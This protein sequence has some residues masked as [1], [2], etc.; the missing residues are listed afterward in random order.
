[1]Y[2]CNPSYLEAKTTRKQRLLFEASRSKKLVRPISTNKLGVV[3][4]AYN[5]NYMRSIGRRIRV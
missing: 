5:S 4:N 2:V 3:V 1:V